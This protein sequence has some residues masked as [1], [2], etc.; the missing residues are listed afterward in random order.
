[1]SSSENNVTYL[2]CPHCT[3]IFFTRAD[4]DVHLRRFGNNPEQHANDYKDTNA[5]IEFGYGSDDN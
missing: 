5:K 4:L 2:K 1:M 3:C